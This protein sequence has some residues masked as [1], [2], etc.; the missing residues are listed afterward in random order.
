M[1]ASSQ[2]GNKGRK[3]LDIQYHALGNL[4]LNYVTTHKLLNFKF[5]FHFSLNHLPRFIQILF[6]GLLFIQHC[7]FCLSLEKIREREKKICALKK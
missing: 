1:L 2:C 4:T 3:S 5:W 7:G 6:Y